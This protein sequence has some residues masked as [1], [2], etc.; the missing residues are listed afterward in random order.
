MTVRGLLWRASLR[1]P[2]HLVR[3]LGWS[4]AEAAPSFASGHA[5]PGAKTGHAV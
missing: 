1:E 2:R 4:F 3:L 5:I